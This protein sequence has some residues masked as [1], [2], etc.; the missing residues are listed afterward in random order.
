MQ[1][2]A[3]KTRHYYPDHPLVRYI[4]GRTHVEVVTDVQAGRI[5]LKMAPH[6]D[7]YIARLIEVNEAAKKRTRS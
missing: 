1:E 5:A 2:V 6:V 3:K 4:K 7:E